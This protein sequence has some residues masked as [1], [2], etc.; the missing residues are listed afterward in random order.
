VIAER[1]GASAWRLERDGSNGLGDSD[2]SA[3]SETRLIPR[4]LAAPAP[5]PTDRSPL[6]PPIEEARQPR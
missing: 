1:E 3:V 6:P 4:V 5:R 2:S